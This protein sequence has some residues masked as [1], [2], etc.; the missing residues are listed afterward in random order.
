MIT[1]LTQFYQK[2]LLDG[3]HHDSVLSA[4][5]PFCRNRK[6]KKSGKIIVFLNPA[7]FFYGY[8]RC[9]GACGNSGFQHWFAHMTGVDPADVPGALPEES[10][11]HDFV[12][13]QKNINADIDDFEEKLSR[14]QLPFFKEATIGVPALAQ[15]RIGYN[16]RYLVFPYFQPDGNCYSARCVHPEKTDD[17]FWY[18]DTA[19]AAGPGG[20]FNIEEIERCAG[21][22]LFL[23][24][25][26][27]NLLAIKQLGFPGVAY[28]DRNILDQVDK[29]LFASL[30]TV[31]FV[32]RNT[33]ESYASARQAAA[34]IGFKVRILKWQPHHPKKY[35]L[36]QY[37]I[38]SG[39]E[40]SRNLGEML[41]LSR[42]FSPFATP[43]W[44]TNH[45]FSTITETAGEEYGGLLS[46]FPLL[47]ERIGGVH[48]INI[49]G[50]G[51]K[52][53]KSSFMIQ[54]A[55]D[56]AAR[57]IPVLYY[58]FENG[59]QR[60]YQRTFARLSRI[61]TGRLNAQDL[62]TEENQRYAG[63]SQ[64]FAQLLRYFRVVNDRKV[65]PELM[66]RHIDFL[67]HETRSEYTVVVID[68]LHKL[69]FKDISEKRSGI[70]SWL[71]QMESIRD[72][73]NVSF[74]VISELSRG[75]GGFYDEQPHM[76]IFKG[77]G[78]IEY[79]AD[80]AMVLLPQWDHMKEDMAT[81][82]NRL[83][84]VGSRE[85]SP[86]LIGQYVLD[87]PFWGFCEEESS[88]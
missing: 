40:F 23:C 7:S 56:M 58:D 15:L 74:L 60:I 61:E 45:F 71:R 1:T 27:E 76:G 9:T 2:H 62:S 36:R 55:T 83:W 26:E 80:N 10:L 33:A 32:P 30:K 64:K 22:T 75:A 49:L 88:M 84:L 51:P 48:G 69:P 72:E 65:S 67:R 53:G 66:R 29:A 11:W 17:Y 47:D 57:Q 24:E 8:F 82:I 34:E 6:T 78:D 37:A 54:I 87:Y 63:V 70:D 16:G 86:G 31:F 79:S 38:V 46:G 25:G 81:R 50:G 52:V 14:E 4:D 41:T 68:S 43:E 39:E 44:E 73:L 85:H 59:R 77:S 18:G 12:Y 5:C 3:V 13:P 19:F 28:F 35:D 21:G 20:L 42:P